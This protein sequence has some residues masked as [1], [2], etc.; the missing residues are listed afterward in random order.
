M[1]FVL[2]TRTVCPFRCSFNQ[3]ADDQLEIVVKAS[4]P[5]SY[6]NGH[7][8]RQTGGRIWVHRWPQS[9]KTAPGVPTVSPV[10]R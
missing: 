7:R 4:A 3:L 9:E 2:S 5:G 8:S 10:V 1:R 6:V